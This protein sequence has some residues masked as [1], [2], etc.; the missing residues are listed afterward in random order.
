MTNPW[1]KINWKTTIASCDNTI[2]TPSYC[3][4]MGIDT[5][6]LPEP[7]SG[8]GVTECQAIQE[9]RSLA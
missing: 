6:Y 8:N 4:K 3:S 1:L 5:T 7:F 9:V 2:I